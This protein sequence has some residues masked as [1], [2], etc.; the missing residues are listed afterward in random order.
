MIFLQWA[1]YV[2]LHKIRAFA[3]CSTRNPQTRESHLLSLPISAPSVK[4]LLSGREDSKF[5]LIYFVN[6]QSRLTQPTSA[7]TDFGSPRI[8]QRRVSVETFSSNPDVDVDE[9]EHID[10]NGG[11]GGGMRPPSPHPVALRPPRD[12]SVRQSFAVAAPPAYP[13]ESYPRQSLAVPRTEPPRRS[14][15]PYSE[16]GYHE[17][18]LQ[19]TQDHSFVD[20]TEN[21]RIDPDVAQR[22]ADDVEFPYRESRAQRPGRLRRFARAMLWPFRFI[23][24]AARL[25][26]FLRRKSST[27]KR[28]VAQSSGWD[29]KDRTPGDTSYHM[30]NSNEGGVEDH[31]T[32]NVTAIFPVAMTAPVTMIETNTEHR[33]DIQGSGSHSSGVIVDSGHARSA[34][35]HSHVSGHS[36]S[37]RSAQSHRETNKANGDPVRASGTTRTTGTTHTSFAPFSP[38]AAPASEIKESSRGRSSRTFSSM[39][40]GSALLHHVVRLYHALRVLYHLPWVAV[41]PMRVTVDVIPALSSRSKYCVHRRPLGIPKAV[42]DAAT[43]AKNMDPSAFGKSWY[44]QSPEKLREKQIQQGKWTCRH[45]SHSHS[46]SN[47]YQQLLSEDQRLRQQMNAPTKGVPIFMFNPSAPPFP[48]PLPFSAQQFYMVPGPPPPP[49][50]GVP[51]ATRAPSIVGGIRSPPAA[52]PPSA[53]SFRPGPRPV[54]TTPGP[55][56]VQ[57]PTSPDTINGDINGNSN[58][59]GGRVEMPRPPPATAQPMYM[60]V[61]A[62]HGPPLPPSYGN[63]YSY[64]YSPPWTPPQRMQ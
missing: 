58:L 48:Q 64:P 53:L 35:P 43:A 16:F 12:S 1:L 29:F 31:G 3:W 24:S 20:I 19:T 49:S 13:P 51:M 4:L 38:T 30:Q 15:I 60:L 33:C 41:P 27:A 63:M 57:N 23:K 40:R 26:K 28:S 47:S 18:Q 21:M 7:V 6:R 50:A 55:G 8:V 5:G 59:V 9:D 61:P 22:F 52:R 32:E 62:P 39:S 17:S 34:S 11:F 36:P 44:R 56:Q 2:T 45:H 37:H 42:L 14:F 46:P 54:Q 25:P 10:Y